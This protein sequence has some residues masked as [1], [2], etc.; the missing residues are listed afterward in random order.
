MNFF[1]ISGVLFPFCLT[2]E[3]FITMLKFI[4]LICDDISYHDFEKAGEE[5]T[6]G[7]MR[8]QGE[9]SNSKSHSNFPSKGP[10]AGG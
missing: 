3:L 1:S 9:G 7:I 5:R 8:T 4:P 2:T 10:K 6:T